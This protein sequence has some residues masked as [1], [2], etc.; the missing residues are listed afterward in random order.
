MSVSAKITFSITDPNGRDDG[1][2]SA[3]DTDKIEILKREGP[4]SAGNSFSVIKTI[5]G[6]ELQPGQSTYTHEDTDVLFKTP[7]FYVA[8]FYRNSETLESDE[9]GPI[10]ISGLHE[11]GYPDNIPGN[12]DGVPNFIG[13]APLL[14]LSAEYEYNFYG[15]QEGRSYQSG[16]VI[17]NQND[18]YPGLGWN[19]TTNFSLRTT[20]HGIPYIN[21]YTA[22]SSLAS[23]GPGAFEALKQNIGVSGDADIVALDQGFT[24]VQVCAFEEHEG[25]KEI[26][27]DQYSRFYY[28]GLLNQTLPTEWDVSNSSDTQKSSSKIGYTESTK[29]HPRSISDG[30]F[31]EPQNIGNYYGPPNG[32]YWDDARG[33][34][35]HKSKYV[36]W[37]RQL[38]DL[39]QT[40]AVGGF[41]S[42]SR[43]D[44]H[45]PL[46]NQVS[47]TV[48]T[49][50]F[51]PTGADTSKVCTMIIRQK[52]DGSGTQTF[53]NG[54]IFNT[55]EHHQLINVENA[56]GH[57]D[58]HVSGYADG[59]AS[60][61]EANGHASDFNYIDTAHS[62]STQ[63]TPN[64]G[65]IHHV[66]AMIN[67]GGF[68]RLVRFNGDSRMALCELMFIPSALT[69]EDFRRLTTYLSNKYDDGMLPQ[70]D[71][72]L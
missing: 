19:A 10:F 15:S 44:Y 67:S 11:L 18:L 39:A 4:A 48:G 16:E 36:L 33:Y 12:T 30:G 21:F 7:Y 5:Q 54:N 26:H 66:P 6:S 13:V 61:W 59:E 43:G 22:P 69:D 28:A 64:Q 71:Y 56:N 9:I 47:K 24:F 34:W 72:S 49:S 51:Y 17:K 60:W 53:I 58:S 37:A 14:H 29:Y 23:D 46:N 45:K 65:Y 32:E 20:S 27:Q 42:Y 50:H 38:W 62:P 63:T 2:A 57:N 70:G 31:Y 41:D 35:M 3:L 40:R 55:A 25:T 8:K 1:V 52:E 68:G